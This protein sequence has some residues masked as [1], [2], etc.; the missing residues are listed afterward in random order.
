MVRASWSV[1]AERVAWTPPTRAEVAAVARAGLAA[2]LAWLLAV[3]LTDV[4]APV[5]APLAALITVRVSVHASIRSAIERS[6]AVVLGVLVAVAIG[7]TLGLNAL[8]VGLLTSASLAF[9]LLVLRL[10]RPAATQVPV[11]ALVVMAALASGEQSYAWMRAF[12]TVL[13]AVVGVGVSLALPASRF[14]DARG[15]MRR[16]A[17]VL[18]EELDAMGDG[19]ATTWSTRETAEWRHTARLTRQRLVEQ[20]TEAIGNGREAAQWNIRD[21]PHVVELGLYEDVMPRLERTAIGVWAI[22]RGLEDHAQL[23]GG[24]HRPME[25]MGSLLVSLA[26]LVRAFTGEV[27]DDH[28]DGG[29][30]AALQDVSVRRAPCA[31]AAHLQTLEARDQEVGEPG[32]RR[33]EWMSYTALLVQV[34]RIVDDLRAPLPS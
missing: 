16:L 33:R 14:D 8:T 7:N 3:A 30:A 18:G 26:N 4:E 34:D 31:R 2:A 12:D 21:R 27:L 5:L 10:P 9:A 19:L 15:S 25:A 1:L 28:P 23:T 20:M 22:A 13:G 29:L 32:D 24:E 11:S 6:G 17:T